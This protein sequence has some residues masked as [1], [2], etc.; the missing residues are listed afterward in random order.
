MTAKIV[1]PTPDTLARAADILRTGGLV[2][3]PTETVYGLACDAA[4]PDAVA[5]LYA[6][7][8][9]PR[10]N[11]L[12]AHVASQAMAEREAVFTPLARAAAERFWPGPLT[13]V[14]PVAATGSVCDLA[15]AGLDTI[16][17]RRPV[18]PV[19]QAL[20]DTFGGPLVA[21]SANRSGHISPTTPAHV[22]ADLADRIALILDGGPC[23]MGI[24]STIVD[25][26]GE[27][28]RLLRAGALETAMIEDALGVTFARPGTDA[29][30]TSP[31]QMKSHYAPRAALRL[32]AATPMSGEGYL[33]FGDHC[34]REGNLSP[35]GDLA[36]AAANLFAMLRALDARFDRIAVA[37]IPHTGLGEAIN[38]RLARAAHRD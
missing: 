12:I 2:A 9:R 16:A 27:T 35:T 6:A 22:L 19:A 25:F 7:K 31:G 15:R 17:L 18:H 1:L 4:N 23:A 38:D 37:P 20:L 32:D 34:P 30:I 13:L 28:P 33:G 29:G 21:P 26:T 3:M 24:E 5:G 11:P 14:L 8:G 36:E 10:F